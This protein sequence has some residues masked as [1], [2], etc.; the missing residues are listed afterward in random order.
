M[1]ALTF[2]GI[3]KIVYETIADPS[4]E[5]DTDVIVRVKQCAIC[6]SDLHVYHGREEGIDMHTA[7]GHEFVGEIVETGKGVKKLKKG[8]MV[9]SPFTTSC[10]ECFYC[11]KGLTCRCIHSQLFGWRE[12]NRGLH[13][14]QSEFV[15]VPKAEGTLVKIPEGVSN[16]DALFLG[17]ILS[18]GF[19]C[20]RQAEIR[21]G[22][23]HAV[24]GCGPVGLMAIAGAIHYGS[25]RVY[26]F[27]NVPER[28]RMAENFGA[29]PVDGSK[30]NP[31]EVMKAATDGRGADAVLEAVG[32]TGAGRLAY[33]LIR[34]GGIISV[35]GVCNDPQMPF[36]PVQAYNKNLTY[37]VGRCPARAMIDELLPMVQA[38]KFNFST[39]ITHRM[40]LSEGV[41]G[42]DIFANKKDNCLKVVL[43]P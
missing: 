33:D 2:A 5:A 15:R 42:Y 13:G 6:G 32:S 1:K 43:T 18:T 23:T 20:A 21:R 17:D 29:I 26:A 27:D 12:D 37:K 14:G 34:P 25:K 9:M 10:G 24:I 31:V 19:F 16:D 36:S 41:K 28:L 22:D 39:I 4:I 7:M 11:R 38:E 8:D 30:T 40:K 35:V 3:E